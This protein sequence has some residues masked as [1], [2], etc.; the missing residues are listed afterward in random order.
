LSA[1]ANSTLEQ[2]RRTRILFDE[3]LRRIK[4]SMTEELAEMPTQEDMEKPVD[5]NEQQQHMY[6]E[7]E[8]FPNEQIE[9]RPEGQNI[10][11]NFD[12][13]RQVRNKHKNYNESIF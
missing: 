12:N 6:L 10:F 2:A 7:S 3:N 1:H 9:K 5:K 11:I 8:D 4:K 13:I